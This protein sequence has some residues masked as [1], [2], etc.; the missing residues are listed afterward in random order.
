[1][2]IDL[3]SSRRRSTP[4]DIKR[5]LKDKAY[6]DGLSE[7][8]KREFIEKTKGMSDADLDNVTRGTGGVPHAAAS[9]GCGVHGSL[10]D[11]ASKQAVTAAAVD[12]GRRRLACR[13][14][15]ERARR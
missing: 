6:L 12:R 8:D 15:A 9:G 10:A 2:P 14:D 7:A 5:A 1:V 11:K 4:V 13:R 3:P